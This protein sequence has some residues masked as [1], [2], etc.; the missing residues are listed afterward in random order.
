MPARTI[1]TIDDGASTPVAHTYKP[2]G[3][4]PG[5]AVLVESD[6]VPVGDKVITIDPKLASNG[7]RKVK[8]GNYQPVTVSETINGVARETLERRSSSVTTFTFA[9]DSTVQERANVVAILRNLLDDQA[10]VQKVLVDGE[11]IW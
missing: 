1:L 9:K 6:G 4:Q 8:L 5:T 3:S 7:D 11:G 2:S 10:F